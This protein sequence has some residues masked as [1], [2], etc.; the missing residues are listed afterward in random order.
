MTTMTTRFMVSEYGV[1]VRDKAG[2]MRR[3]PGMLKA[4]DQIDILVLDDGAFQPRPVRI[5]METSLC[6]THSV[7]AGLNEFS[8]EISRA[9]AGSIQSIYM[10]LACRERTTLSVDVWKQECQSCSSGANFV[11][12]QVPSVILP[13]RRLRKYWCLHPGSAQGESQAQRRS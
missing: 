10:M 4:R 1:N 12:A 7:A 8:G 5:F 3:L 2:K 11:L 13:L 9:D 6:R